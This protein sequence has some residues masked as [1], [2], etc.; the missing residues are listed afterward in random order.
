MR[1]QTSDLRQ[2][3]MRLTS[4]IAELQN[5]NAQLIEDHTRDVLQIKAKETQLVRARSDAEN[6]EERANSLSKE[7]DRLKRE[8]SR[9][10]RH[11]GAGSP[12]VDHQQGNTMSGLIHNGDTPSS[13][14]P[15]YAS[16][17]SYNVPSARA[18]GDVQHGGSGGEGKEN[19]PA[20]AAE[21]G[22]AGGPKLSGFSAAH[23]RPLSNGS[24]GRA[25]PSSLA[26]VQEASPPLLNRSQSEGV[27]SW[28]RAAEVT[29]NLKARIEMMKV[30]SLW[31]CCF[32]VGRIC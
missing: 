19:V 18:Y 7:I 20:T 14:R 11:N 8:M 5:Q 29:Q 13:G 16:S 1:D 25:T 12:P 27:E 24:S 6:A 10:G 23:T 17:R 9:L 2:D 21:D 31:Q 28:R 22:F 3:K 32:D 15:N 26:D 4:Q 30:C